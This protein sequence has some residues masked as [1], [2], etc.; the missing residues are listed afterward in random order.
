MY[1]SELCP[2]R[3]DY[4]DIRSAQD[5]ASQC[6][7]ADSKPCFTFVWNPRTETCKVNL[8]QL[9]GAGLP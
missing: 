2:T 8:M 9:E 1:R 4:S 7:N 6:V 3:L 5:C